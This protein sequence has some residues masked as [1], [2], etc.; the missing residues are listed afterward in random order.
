MS[1]G[2]RLVSFLIFLIVVFEFEVVQGNPLPATTLDPEES[3]GFVEGDM[4]LSDTQLRLIKG[5]SKVQGRNGLIDE[6]KRWPDA[7]VYYKIVGDFDL[8]HRNAILDGISTL[9]SRTCIRFR[10]ADSSQKHYVAITSQSG[11]C[12][13][14]V[15][16]QRK[17]QQMNLQIFPL[18]EGCFR[19][20]TI[21]HEFMHALGF[22]HQQSDSQ[23]DD[24]I[25]VVY[26]NIVPG[27]EFNFDKYS[28]SLVTDFDVGYDYDSC[29]HY[30]PGAFSQ[31]GEDTIVPLDPKAKIGQRV[32]LSEKD[33]KKINIMY[34][35]PIK[36]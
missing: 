17:V 16:Y 6:N 34:K 33:V 10:E 7:I 15:G 32:S 9:E 27:K 23:R 22:Y 18:G 26:E 5:S 36:I 13:T 30:R 35:C 25:R 3:A 24:Y 2:V 20:G 1:H 11:G 28:S 8:A 14:A 12:F 29:L 21:L 19:T 31:N 4:V